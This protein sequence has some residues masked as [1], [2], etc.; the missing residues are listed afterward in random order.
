[1]TIVYIRKC[2]VNKETV[3][4]HRIS[5]F[6]FRIKSK[7]KAIDTTVC[8]KFFLK[9]VKVNKK[10]IGYESILFKRKKKHEIHISFQIF[11]SE[12]MVISPSAIEKFSINENFR[13]TIIKSKIDDNKQQQVVQN[14]DERKVNKQTSFCG[15]IMGHHGDYKVR[16]PRTL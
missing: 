1:M 9:D 14:F 13:I 4:T 11:I 15:P 12:S 10:K 8:I 3:A 5:R 6:Q 2:I 7:I 16:A